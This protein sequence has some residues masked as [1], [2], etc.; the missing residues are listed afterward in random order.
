MGP[1]RRR[2]GQGNHYQGVT[3]T[4]SGDSVWDNAVDLFGADQQKIDMA[5]SANATKAIASVYGGG[6][7]FSTNGGSA[8]TKTELQDAAWS[9]VAISSNG[10]HAAAVVESGLLCVYSDTNGEWRSVDTMKS[11]KW[12]A[13]ALSDDGMFMYATVY[14]GYVYASSDFGVTWERD[15]S[16]GSY[17][18]WAGIVINQN[19]GFAIT[20]SGRMFQI[21]VGGQSTYQ[22]GL[23]SKTSA[24][25]TPGWKSVD[26]SGSTSPRGCVPGDIAV[27]VGDW[28]DIYTSRNRGESW[29]FA[30]SEGDLL[31]TS[32][33][34]SADGRKRIAVAQGRN[35][36]TGN[37]H[38]AISKASDDE[39]YAWSVDRSEHVCQ[40]L[41]QRPMLG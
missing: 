4:Y 19:R 21:N 23:I 40:L 24:A 26:C 41:V 38:V 29:E 32:V 36:L 35:G 34:V 25:Q 14:D 6:V 3:F 5:A 13:V 17:D 8:W 33:A 31:W 22:G 10:S 12:S 27:A 30:I 11:R 18:T 1:T 20:E 7:Y 2:Q 39:L 28:G 37:G 15:V 9:A 16:P